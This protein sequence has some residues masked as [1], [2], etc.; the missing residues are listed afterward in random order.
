MS[1]FNA[2]SAGVPC[3]RP[4]HVSTYNADSGDVLCG[5]LD[6]CLPITRTVGT[7]PTA[8]LDEC[9]PITRTV[10]TYPAADPAVVPVHLGA[11]VLAPAARAQEAA[12]EFVR[13]P[14]VVAAAAPAPRVATGGRSEWLVARAPL[15]VSETARAPHGVH[16]PRRRDA[17]RERRLAETCPTVRT[18]VHRCNVHLPVHYV[19]Y[20]W[21]Y[22]CVLMTI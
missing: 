12:R 2:E 9:L 22:I 6:V 11:R 4:W 20:Y 13:I 10:K 8:E 17:E 3:D 1:S 15:E 16:E 5:R 18:L 14:D 19:R 7:Y 21:L